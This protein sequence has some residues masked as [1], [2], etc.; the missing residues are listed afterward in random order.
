M[1][2]KWLKLKKAS[3]QSLI[4]YKNNIF[5]IAPYYVYA[6]ARARGVSKPEGV[7]TELGIV[8][9]KTLFI[10]ERGLDVLFGI[11]ILSRRAHYFRVVVRYD[12]VEEGR[13]TFFLSLSYIRTTKMS[14]SYWSNEDTLF[15]KNHVGKTT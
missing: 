1:E 15:V 12:G 3:G 13:K 11:F 2:I 10:N 7:F 9:D 6:R 14:T 5:Y 4:G 8:F